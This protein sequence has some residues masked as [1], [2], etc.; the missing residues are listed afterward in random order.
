MRVAF[1]LSLLGISALVL[2]RL[3][4]NSLKALAQLDRGLLALPSCNFYTFSKTT[5]AFP[6]ITMDVRRLN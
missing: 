5:T 2:E 6:N 4:A 1:D 3:G